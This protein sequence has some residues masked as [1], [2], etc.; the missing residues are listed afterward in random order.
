MFR[1]SG[2]NGMDGAGIQRI[3]ATESENRWRFLHNPILRGTR[4]RD[5]LSSIGLALHP[6]LLNTKDS[7]V[8]W[9]GVVFEIECAHLITSC[10]ENVGL[11]PMIFLF[12]TKTY[13]LLMPFYNVPL[14]VR[15]K[16][17]FGHEKTN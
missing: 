6:Y 8:F 10:N 12:I 15:L 9:S 1:S 2:L 4:S 14:L 7:G 3:P 11:S 13:N 5:R 16:W 17:N